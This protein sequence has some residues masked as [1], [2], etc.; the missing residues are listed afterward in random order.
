MI[1]RITPWSGSNGMAYEGT[2]G[3][4]SQSAAPRPHSIMSIPIIPPWPGA[5][6]VR[7]ISCS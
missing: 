3:C 2:R 4:G 5:L 6:R 7:A 1:I